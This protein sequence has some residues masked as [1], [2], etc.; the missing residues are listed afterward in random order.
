MPIQSNINVS[1]LVPAYNHE[2]YI[3]ECI[4]SIFAQEYEHFEVIVCD[5][6]STD[7]TFEKLTKYIDNSPVPFQLVRNENNSGICFSLNRLLGLAKGTWI[8]IIASDDVYLPQFIAENMALAKRDGN[9]IKAIHSDVERIDQFGVIISNR[10]KAKPPVQGNAFEEKALQRA[11]VYAPT[12]FTSKKMY[13]LVGGF[14]GS[15][16]AEDLD[17]QLRVARI[18]D[19]EYIPKR[20]MA[21]REVVGGL[22]QKARIWNDD[23]FSALE[24]HI[25]YPGLNMT[26]VLRYRLYLQSRR[27]GFDFDLHEASRLYSKFSK[28]YRANRSLYLI[29]FLY[30]GSRRVAYLC[31]VNAS[32]FVKNYIM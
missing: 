18:T 17:I 10:S 27:A 14:D 23:I 30:G 1:I 31:K 15:L 13:E 32:K 11:H 3:C 20:L 22:G 8:A 21:K 19:F 4:E 9:E 2:N 12:F 25:D 7:A 5:D 24:K 29:Y 6:A 16:K 26:K 28:K